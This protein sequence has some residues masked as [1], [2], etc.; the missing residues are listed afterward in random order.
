MKA[1]IVDDEASNLENLQQ[2][3]KTYADDVQICAVAE[4]VE[5]ALKAIKQHQPQLVF[6]DIQ[7]H[8][9]TGFD[10]LKQLGEINF[11]IIFIT[12]YNQYAIQAIRFSALD[13]LLKPISFERFSK[14]V[15]KIVDGRLFTQK[16]S[17]EQAGHIF[18]KSNN[19]FFKVNF[20]EIIYIEGMKDYLKIYTA[21]Y[22]LVT[23]QTMSEMEKILPSKQ[24]M[25]VH[26]SYIVALAYIRSIYGNSIETQKGTIPIGNSYKDKMMNFVVRK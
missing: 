4:S 7:L 12:A 23:H 13:Y 3:L 25:R 1:L 14:A 22:R 6:L 17:M 9:Q 24:F 18:I 19:K 16:E 15:N 26:K 21:E 8:A 20:S 2:L 11:E 5:E 10:L